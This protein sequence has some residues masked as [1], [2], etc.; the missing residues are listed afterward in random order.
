MNKNTSI[1]ISDKSSG[2][3]Y[4][5]TYTVRGHNL[6]IIAG[7]IL[8]DDDG[9]IMKRFLPYI[10]SLVTGVIFG[11]FIFQETDFDIREV[12]ADT[13]TV[14]AFQLGV[15][16]NEQSALDLKSRHAGSI[17]MK[18][19]D[20]YRVYF[21]LLT[22]E[23]VIARMSQ[24]LTNQNINYFQR[25]ITVRD[26]DLIRA[27]NNYERTMVEGSEAVLVSVNKLITSSYKG[28]ET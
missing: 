15:F 22:N 3:S 16:N 23:R 8:Y 9:D 25:Q 17:I 13:M 19:E 12:F 6:A 11:F 5:T 26:S 27:I 7:L 28:S 21:S 10:C 14:T 20:V 2:R 4:F 18:D 24:Y 1:G